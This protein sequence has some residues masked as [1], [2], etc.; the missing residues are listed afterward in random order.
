VLVS[1]D[2]DAMQCNGVVNELIELVFHVLKTTLDD[3]VSVQ[4]FGQSD[5]RRASGADNHL[6]LKAQKIVCIL[7]TRENIRAV[8]SQNKKWT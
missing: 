1:G 3:M 6:L 4:I 7:L 2:T 8:R 5:N